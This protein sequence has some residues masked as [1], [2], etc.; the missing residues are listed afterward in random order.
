MYHISYSWYILP[1]ILHTAPGSVQGIADS[2]SEDSETQEE[3]EP[4]S[5]DQIREM[6]S[7][8]NAMEAD[9][10]AGCDFFTRPNG[11]GTELTLGEL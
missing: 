6:D 11:K 9:V 8:V 4:A 3:S 7:I 2:T 10:T 5:N 1:F